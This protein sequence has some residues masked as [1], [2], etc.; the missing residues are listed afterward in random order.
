MTWTEA[1]SYCR[2][3]YKDL[4]TVSSEEESNE[5]VMAA[6][7]YYNDSVWIGLYDD[8]NSWRWSLQNEGFYGEGDSEFHEWNSGEPNN[9]MGMED[10]VVMMTNGW[11]DC[12]CLIKY[13]FVCY[14]GK[15]NKL[16]LQ[17]L[18]VSFSC[19]PIYG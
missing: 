5:L 15:K 19:L 10:C 3:H 16:Q 11:N 1:Q 9:F 4:A 17:I 8:V 14:N 6:Q 18:L 7:E 2:E 12:D 13:P